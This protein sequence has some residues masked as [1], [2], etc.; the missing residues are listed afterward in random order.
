MQTTYLFFV[1][2]ISLGQLL[3]VHSNDRYKFTSPNLAQQW[4]SSYLLV[5]T[6]NYQKYDYAKGYIYADFINFGFNVTYQWGNAEAN[7]ILL[8]PDIEN[9]ILNGYNWVNAIKSCVLYGPFDLTEMKNDF[10]WE[11]PANATQLECNN[12]VCAWQFYSNEINYNTTMFV[13]VKNG[14]VQRMELINYHS[15]WFPQY[16]NITFQFND[17]NVGPFDKSVYDKP[18]FCH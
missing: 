5:A 15:F 13:N 1:I 18:A 11:I 2:L 14:G 17:P 12:N 6:D 3:F 16:S 7:T 10:R 8:N 9:N 4:Q